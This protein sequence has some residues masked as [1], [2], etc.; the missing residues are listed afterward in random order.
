M[1]DSQE[2]RNSQ[3]SS[4]MV[5]MMAIALLLLTAVVIILGIKIQN[6]D[7]VI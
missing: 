2:Y 3:G 5:K 4:I 6:M 7:S 1:M